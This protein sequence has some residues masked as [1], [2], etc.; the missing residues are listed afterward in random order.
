[1]IFKEDLRRAYTLNTGS[2]L[3][4]IV[5]CYRS[6]GVH[7][8]AVFR[9]GNW[10]TRK[11]RLINLFLLPLYWLLDHRIRAK[12]GI[13][14]QAQATISGGFYIHHFG[15]IFVSGYSVIGKDF[16]LSHDVT[17]G[18]AGEG[19]KRGAPTIGDNVF[20]APGAKV[21]GKIKIGSNTKIGPNAVVNRD[22]QENSLVHVPEMRI[23]AFPNLYPQQ[24]QGP[25]S[26]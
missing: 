9:F 22:V 19:K 7:A 5:D 11:S 25:E 18:A 17:I 10:V 13:Q 3:G 12:W 4:K 23:V 15:G 21:N 26:P 16:T 14:I 24:I 8:I 6:P 1:M 2:K 20:V